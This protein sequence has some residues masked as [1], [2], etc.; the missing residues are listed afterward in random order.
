MLF[1][2]RSVGNVSGAHK[3]IENTVD[4]CYSN[5]RA[6][7]LLLHDDV[8]VTIARLQSGDARLAQ[9]TR[10]IARPHAI[11]R[12]VRNVPVVFH[13]QWFSSLLHDDRWV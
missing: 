7:K 4:P 8:V 9:L 5:V 11:A 12:Q 6:I 1:E 2:R 10:M 13:S 3:R